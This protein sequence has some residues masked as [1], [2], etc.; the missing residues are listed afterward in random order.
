M[1]SVSKALMRSQLTGLGLPCLAA[2]VVLVLGGLCISGCG[3]PKNRHGRVPI[4]G[5][6]TLDGVPLKTGFVVFEPKSGQPTQS[7]GMIADG[8]FEVPAPHGAAPGTYSVAFYSGDGEAPITKY[9]PGTP[10]YE[11]VAMKAAGEQVP[12]KYNIDT[13]LTAEVTEDGDNF[14]PFELFRDK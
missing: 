12:R 8:K 3:G 6:V 5:T 9:E 14:F 4:S 1:T 11:A 7:G 2:I 10:E 13:K